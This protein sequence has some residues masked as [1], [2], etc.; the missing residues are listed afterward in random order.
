ME[1]KKRGEEL[2]KGCRKRGR[3]R[4]DGGPATHPQREVQCKAEAAKVDEGEGEAF[5]GDEVFDVVYG[6]DEDGEA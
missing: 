4:G 2:G 1:G 5:R 3:K 6:T